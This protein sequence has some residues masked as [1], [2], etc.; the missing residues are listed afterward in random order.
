M[1]PFVI[2]HT[3][4]EKDL[5]VITVIELGISYDGENEVRMVRMKTWHPK[6]SFFKD[7]HGN[8]KGMCGSF[9]VQSEEFSWRPYSILVCQCVSVYVDRHRLC[10]CDQDGG[11]PCSIIKYSPYE[12]VS[13]LLAPSSSSGDEFL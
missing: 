4:V 1:A 13:D 2:R 11:W 8:W 7:W 10:L 5:T 6:G 12:D 3:L 9:E